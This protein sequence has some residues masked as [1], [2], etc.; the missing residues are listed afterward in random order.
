MAPLLLLAA[1]VVPGQAWAI[2]VEKIEIEG[3]KR[4]ESSAIRQKIQS[5]PG[6]NVT[7][8]MIR[9]DIRSIFSLGFFD[10]VEVEREAA[11]KGDVLIFLVKERP[12]VNKLKFDGLDALE[13]DEVKTAIPTK[14]F[15]V[16][17]I[18]K[19]NQSVQKLGE[20]YEEK[21][22]YLAEVQYQM[23]LDEARNEA[24]VTFHI[25]ENDKVQVK[26]INIIGNKVVTDATLKGFMQTQE[27]GLLSFLTG[28]GSY[29]EAVFERDVG[30]LG[31]YYAT[32][33]YVRA[34]FGKPEV[35]VS[36]DKKY[37]FITIS[38]EEGE[39]Y[40]VGKVDF[41]GELL[42]SRAELED[43]LLLKTG[44]TFNT[45]TLRRE[46][47]RLTEKY[48]D[49]GYAFANVVPQPAINDETRVVD[50]TFEVDKG[51]R[52]YVGQITVTGNTRTKDHVVRR[53][54]RIFE[55]ELFNGT[56]KRESRENVLRLGFFDEVDFHQTTSKF[57]DDIVD[58]EIKV[59]ER[60]TGQLVIGAGYGSGQTGFTFNAQL[61]QNNFMGNGQVA[62]F[63]A[64]IL[65]GQNF[66]EFNLGFSDPYLGGTSL[67]SLGGDLYQLRRTMYS[68]ATVSVPT[69]DETKTGF[70][71]K[72]G[73]PVLDF[74]YL[75]L[76]Y[77]LEKSTVDPASIIDRSII[78]PSSVNGISS[79]LTAS[80]VY[81]KRDDRFDP[82]NGL[83]WSL[84]GEY[85]G[86]A[87]DRYFTRTRA[88]VR[89]FKPVFWD[90]VFRTRLSGGNVSPLPGHS[91]PMNELF[92]QGGLMSLR[93][94]R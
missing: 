78:S 59:K 10:T 76:T 32:L 25:V 15:E 46:T 44:D 47:L 67:W 39:Q 69:F 36:P 93:G 24:T 9:Q 12:I 80:M 28:S 38:V 45:D 92:I 58:I 54:L 27:G 6:S 4:I 86:V 72:L 7:L 81:D 30:T 53:E 40:T 70:D 14:E 17:D 29:R 16:L 11:G 83:Y 31:Y 18:H 75:Y 42:Y 26:E 23:A 91:V 64:Q 57:S 8:E 41:S 37:I 35:T 43:G 85:A 60:S 34:R 77:K 13:A 89:F 88:E 49:L 90:V 82:R 51:Q 61:S 33:G 55:G 94:Y 71:V 63:S 66:Y 20:M 79:T 48:S 5:K 50:F 73:H 84:S 68:I 56:K 19:L 74:T 2:L 62:S 52:V 1:T 22:H 65:T 3:N 87:G 21:G